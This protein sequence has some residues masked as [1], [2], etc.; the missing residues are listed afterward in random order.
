[1]LMGDFAGV[2]DSGSSSSCCSAG[3]LLVLSVCGSWLGASVLGFAM[4]GSRRPMD[5]V[6]L[7]ANVLDWKEASSCASTALEI[8]LRL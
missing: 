6:R 4:N 5:R 3:V 2:W 8:S 1:M 7:R